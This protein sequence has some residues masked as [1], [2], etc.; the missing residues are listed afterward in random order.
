MS[1]T[2]TPYASGMKKPLNMMEAPVYPDI[3]KG[4]PRFVWS[5]KHWNVDTGAT[6]MSTEPFTQLLENVVLAQSRDYNKTIYGQSSYRE[7]VNAEFR[8]PL[9]SH[10]EDVGPLNRVPTK[11]K[12]LVPRINPATAGYGSGTS[13]FTSKNDRPSDIEKALTDRVKKGDERPTFYAPFDVP[14][15]NSVLPDL[16]IKLPAVSLASGWEFDYRSTLTPKELE[17]REKLSY[18]PLNPGLMSNFRFTGNSDLENYQA[19]QNLPSISTNSGMNIPFSSAIPVENFEFETKL[20]SISITSGSNN[21]FLKDNTEKSYDLKYH[22][23][24]VSINSGVNSSV[25]SYNI[26]TPIEELKY[27]NP[28]VSVNSGVTSSVQSYNIET[29]I[30]ELKYRKPQ[31]SVNSGANSSVQSYNIET[32]IDELDFS[33]P[34][35]SVNSG[36][37][38]DYQHYELEQTPIFDLREKLSSV[39]INVTN[40]GVS[41]NYQTDLNSFS[42]INE[43]HLNK[44][45]MNYS[46]QTSKEVGYQDRNVMTHK[47]SYHEKLQPVKSYGPKYSQTGCSIP[48]RNFDIPQVNIKEKTNKY[49]INKKKPMYKL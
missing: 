43:K 40:P 17:L 48:K 26:E 7:I 33:R 31:V 45:H 25:Q 20:P 37:S 15:D 24:Q 41:E 36:V 23:P 32:P 6:L 21:P 35:V 22:N 44:K 34:Q 49:A 29:P 13:G 11:I 8:P 14:Q 3:K 47:P 27:R 42:E 28:Q 16:E 39:P 5:K 4:P 46:Y 38:H 9:I 30:D 12:S 19:K 10:Y 2:S 1:A 18:A